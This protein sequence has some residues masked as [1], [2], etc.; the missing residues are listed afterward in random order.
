MQISHERAVEFA[1]EGLRY[2]DLLRWGWMDL[3][4]GPNPMLDILITHDNELSRL[5]PGRE[6]LAIPQDELDVNPNMK[7]NEGW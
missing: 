6:Y 2:V 3:S 1:F 4:N 7:Q 5:T